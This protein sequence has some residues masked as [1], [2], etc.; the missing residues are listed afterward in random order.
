MGNEHPDYVTGDLVFVVTV[1][2]DSLYKR[3]NNDLHMV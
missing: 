3:V 2:E 1:K